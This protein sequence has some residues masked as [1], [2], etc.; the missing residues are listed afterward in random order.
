MPAAARTDRP[1]DYQVWANIN[2]TPLDFRLNAGRFGLE[3]TAGVWGTATLQQY[4]GTN[5]AYFP[6]SAAIAAN[7]YT[8]LDLPSG[9]YQLTLAG[10]TGLKGKIQKIDAG[11]AR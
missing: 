4:D 7:G 1:I 9:Q 11:R 6:V 10:V 3:L 2:A 5:D 8:V